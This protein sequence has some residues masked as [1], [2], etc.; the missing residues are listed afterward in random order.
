MEFTM[1]CVFAGAIDA[2]CARRVVCQLIEVTSLNTN[3]Y[4]KLLKG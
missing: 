2:C 3:V 1:S 4:I